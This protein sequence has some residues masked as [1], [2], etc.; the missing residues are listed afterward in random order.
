MEFDWILFLGISIVGPLF[1]GKMCTILEVKITGD[2]RDEIAFK[3]KKI[4]SAIISIGIAFVLTGKIMTVIKESPYGN[5]DIVLKILS[6]VIGVNIFL[7]VLRI[8]YR[9]ALKNYSRFMR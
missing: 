6:I 8:L 1:G 9:I 3:K 7:I 2:V 5:S 4:K